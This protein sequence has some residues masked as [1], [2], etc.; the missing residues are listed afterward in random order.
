MAHREA[1]FAKRTHCWLAGQVCPSQLGAQ[2][3]PLGPTAQKKASGQ[4]A[5]ASGEHGLPQKPLQTSPAAQDSFS[6]IVRARHGTPSE[7]WPAGVQVRTR[8]P[9]PRVGTTLQVC[10]PLHCRSVKHWLATQNPLFPLNARHPRGGSQS[11]WREQGRSKVSKPRRSSTES[12]GLIFRVPTEVRSTSSAGCGPVHRA[13]SSTTS[14]TGSSS[15]S[16]IRM[17]ARRFTGRPTHR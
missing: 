15:P 5:A 9:L 13:L 12:T 14:G 3:G 11:S 1:P 8:G 4:E 10:P 6:F 7:S 16:K 17:K 2:A